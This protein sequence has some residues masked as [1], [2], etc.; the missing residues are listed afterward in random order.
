MTFERS[1]K[2]LNSVNVS[3]I[4]EISVHKEDP[5]IEMLCRNASAADQAGNSQKAIELYSEAISKTENRS[6]LKKLY[7][8][9]AQMHQKVKDFDKALRDSSMGLS[10]D[11]F[12]E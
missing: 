5:E 7:Y 8:N 4:D 3:S 6:T 2:G 12:K 10:L 11:D 1:S 9:R